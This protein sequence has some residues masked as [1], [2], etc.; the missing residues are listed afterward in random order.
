MQRERREASWSAGRANG[1]ARG[2]IRRL[3]Q[4][5]KVWILI[6]NEGVVLNRR[7]R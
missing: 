3:R 1:L 6:H 5:V 7:R 2:R 4:M